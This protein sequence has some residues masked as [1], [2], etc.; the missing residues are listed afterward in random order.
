MNAHAD[1]KAADAIKAS[2][3]QWL[4]ALTVFLEAR[5]EPPEGQQAV[6]HVIMNRVKNPKVWSDNIA[7]VIL[8]PY[9]FS[10]FNV[11]SVPQ[12]FQKLYKEPAAFHDALNVAAGVL[13]EAYPDNTFGA[14]HYHTTGI[15]LPNWADKKRRTVTIGDHIFY[16]LYGPKGTVP[17]ITEPTEGR[18]VDSGL[19]P[20]APGKET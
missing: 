4:L 12:L 15:G 14:D 16:N 19:S 8:Q 5:G 18:I 6:A 20:D 10:C 2:L 13:R 7:G 9:Q 11:L 17:R 1:N 3:D